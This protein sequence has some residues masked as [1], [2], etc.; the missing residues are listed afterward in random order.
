MAR[1]IEIYSSNRNRQQYPLTSYFEIPFC[2][3]NS[4]NVSP[5][6][7]IINGAIYYKWTSVQ[8][9]DSGLLETDSTNSSPVLSVIN[10]VTLTSQPSSFDV[11]NGFNFFDFNNFTLRTILSYNPT[12]GSITLNRNGFN[13]FPGDLYT[14]YDPSTSSVIHIPY[15][16]YNGNKIKREE[17]YYDNYYI[18]DETLSYGLDIVAR[19]ISKYDSLLQMA[20]LEYPFPVSWS[21]DDSYTLRKSLPI[22]KWTLQELTF[23]NNNRNYGPLGPVITLPEGASNI[24]GY[25]RGKYIYFSSNKPP[26]ENKDEFKPIYG[27][28]Y[29]KDYK[30][31]SLGGG[32][33]K[34][35]V[36]VD[37]DINNT[38]LPY[39]PV[40]K[41]VFLAGT[42]NTNQFLSNNLSSIENFYKDYII[43]NNTTGEQRT[44]K[45]YNAVTKETTVDPPFTSAIAGNLYTITTQ[46]T[47]NI[48]SLNSENF[49]P[50][51]YTGTMVG[52]NDT[53]CYE[54]SLIELILPN[55][56]LKTG[57][58]I[59][60]YPYVYV[61]LASVSAPN[62]YSKNIIYSN[63]PNS[64]R[65]LFTA[66]ITDVVN[67]EITSFIKPNC[68]I[69]QIVKFKP[70]DNFRFSVYL[71][72]GKLFE[73]VANDFKSPYEP[74]EKLQIH[75][76]FSIKRLDQNKI[77][78]IMF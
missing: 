44:I 23:I 40:A 38:S 75:A 3:Y 12:K 57:S 53:V 76:T 2:S 51:N 60:F 67:P 9:I 42:G 47:I 58:K 69:T 13:I 43:I 71:P 56:D 74:N 65:A 49:S 35:E 14:I 73:T 11:Y 5:S 25:Y 7:P 55:V 19:K 77:E 34:R 41:G 45:S 68:L 70:N 16:D 78:E 26:I 29:I 33:Y 20:Y 24:N 50:L 62:T 48:V 6:D 21:V 63:N 17:R 22:E 46:N 1:Y 18:M 64:G 28:Y 37:Y 54:V 32:N 59:V 66:A 36:F 27:N 4:Y 61:E 39:F 31:T 52:Q 72:N 8:Q 15:E 10:G 30:V